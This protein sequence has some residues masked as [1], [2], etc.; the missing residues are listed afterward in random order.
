MYLIKV[1]SGRGGALTVRLCAD[2]GAGSGAESKTII[3][4]WML[5]IRRIFVNLHIVKFLC[6]CK[7]KICL[8]ISRTPKSDL[9]AGFWYM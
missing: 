6:N 5:E 8:N 1:A 7:S 2:H 9:Y 3:Q 4:R